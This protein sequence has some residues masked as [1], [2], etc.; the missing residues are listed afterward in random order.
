[1]REIPEEILYDQR[2]IERHIEQGLITREDVEKRQ[3]NLPDVKDLGEALDT[4]AL[5]VEPKPDPKG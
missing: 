3:A 5:G 4:V 2:L 1:M